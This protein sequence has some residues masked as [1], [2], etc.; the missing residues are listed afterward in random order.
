MNNLFFKESIVKRTL[1]NLVVSV[2]SF[3]FLLL[4]IMYFQ[5]RGEGFFLV[6][7]FPVFIGFF[8]IGILIYGLF[9]VLI[10]GIILT[11]MVLKNVDLNSGY[12]RDQIKIFVLFSWEVIVSVIF[13]FVVL[14][15]FPEAFNLYAIFESI[16][17][18]LPVE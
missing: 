17:T 3:A 11:N 10:R 1:L 7:V 8:F 12:S 16:A 15:S 2:S 4:A 13:L 14:R 5:V 9:G 6:F 18:D